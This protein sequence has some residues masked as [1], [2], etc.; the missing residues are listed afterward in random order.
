[1]VRVAQEEQALVLTVENTG[2]GLTPRW[3]EGLGLGN[4]RQRLQADF[5]PR[6]TVTVEQNDTR[7]IATIRMP[8][9]VPGR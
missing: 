1:V 8:R 6:A 3:H 5:G 7:T 4:L 2:A 9:A